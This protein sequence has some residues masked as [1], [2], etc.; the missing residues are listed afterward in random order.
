MRTK[1]FANLPPTPVEHFKLYFY[2]AVLHL[3]ERVSQSFGSREAAFEQFPFLTG[4]YDE[5]ATQG[6]GGLASGDLAAWWRDSLHAWEDIVPGHL[7]LRALREVSG[8]GHTAMTMLLS[9]GL[10]E[11]DARFGL[12]FEAMHG[13]QGQHRPTVGLFNTWW[14]DANE[15]GGIRTTL[16]RLQNLGLI[17]IVNSD[18]ARVEWALQL[19]GLLW[20]ILHGEMH[21]TLTSWARYHPPVQLTPY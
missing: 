17:H 13:I 14:R 1:P 19:P 15:D 18:A 2:A 3:I 16:R 11:E 4:Y 6:L 10:I 9:I 5:L 12:L 7:P 20:D 8:L 21:E